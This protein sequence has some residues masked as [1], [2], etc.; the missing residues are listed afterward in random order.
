MKKML[1][2]RNERFVVDNGELYI[3]GSSSNKLYD[4]NEFSMGNID[5]LSWDVSHKGFD[6]A[7][8]E[9]YVEHKDINIIINKDNIGFFK[10]CKIIKKNVKNTDI[11]V[12]KLSIIDALIASHYARK[13]HKTLV[14]ESASDAY[15][16]FYYHGGPIKYKL[17][18]RPLD[19]LAKH[20]HKK[21]DYIVY[22]SQFFLQNKYP[23]KAEAL[24]CPD[25]LLES[26]PIEVLEKRLARIDSKGDNEYV[27][28]LIGATQAEYR[29]HDVLI[30]AV[31]ILKKKGI[32]CKIKFL[33]GG[34]MNDKR[35]N[36]AK[37]NG[38]ED[39]VEFCGR[40]PRD[41]V[42]DWLDDVDILAM[43]TKVESLGRAALEAMSRGCPVIGTIETAL[44]EI[45]CGD[46]LIHPEDYKRLAEILER[47]ITDKEYAKICAKTNFYSV[48]RYE[49]DRVMQIRRDFYNK[50][51]KE[52]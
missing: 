19:T 36:C 8:L 48:S 25:V 3:T 51:R 31:G 42:F 11:V 47:I 16:A 15:A 41:K 44:A 49:K 37:A 45:I 43:P 50:I 29:G 12:A 4:C 30:K 14:I 32:N 34:T 6:V 18:A 10:K 17:A 2:V 28:G 27:I 52:G 39:S 23:S 1:L 13:Y 40:V 9:K 33:G 35:I 7:N 26:T 20:Y 24:G 22:V 5:I 46:C 21:A 38:V